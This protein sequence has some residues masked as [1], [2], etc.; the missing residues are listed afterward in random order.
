MP[1]IVGFQDFWVAGSRFYFQEDGQANPHLLDLGTVGT[2]S[3]NFEPTTLDL[4][5]S[6]GGRE[7]LI[8]QSFSDINE[9]YEIECN[10]ISSDNLNLFLFGDGRSTLNQDTTLLSNDAQFTVTEADFKPGA[11]IKLFSNG[12]ALYN[13]LT[14]TAAIRTTGGAATLEKY[15]G[16]N[17]DTADYEVLSLERGLLRV[18]STGTNSVVAGNVIQITGTADALNDG[19]G[20]KILPQKLGSPKK[21]TGFLFFSR[22]NGERQSVRK[23]RCSIV[24]NAA[25][26][27]IEDYSTIS[28]TVSVLTDID[29]ADGEVAGHMLE[30]SN[31]QPSVSPGQNNFVGGQGSGDSG[32]DGGT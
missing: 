10:N 8:D 14:I 7:N 5:D 18:F 13:L 24:P 16:T 6:D 20:R 30:L 17:P 29:A 9:S 31:T 11:V 26:F 32:D 28:F 23:F 12:V 3:P 15:D 22:N 1:G 19:D 4:K 25:N 2:I 21:G 27:Q